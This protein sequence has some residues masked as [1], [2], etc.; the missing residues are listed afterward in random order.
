MQQIRTQ[1]QQTG[2]A[3]AEDWKRYAAQIRAS[4]AQGTLPEKEVV[5]QRQNLVTLLK[6]EIDLLDKRNTITKSQLSDL[7]AMTLELER[8]ASFLKGTGGLTA[9]T[10]AFLGQA[11]GIGQ[12]L[13]S[14]LVGRLGANLFGVAGGSQLGSIAGSGALG[15][16]LGELSPATIASVASRRHSLRLALLP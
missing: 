1:S 5:A 7:K 13:V 3:V 6:L 12:N 16:L 2:Q 14:Q 15:G 11:G 9:G 4:V 10:S 8:Q